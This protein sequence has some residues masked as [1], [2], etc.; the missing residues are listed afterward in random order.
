MYG[1]AGIV[2]VTKRLGRESD[3]AYRLR[4]LH[5]KSF[6]ARVGLAFG[7]I[8]TFPAIR[9]CC[10]VSYR[11]GKVTSG[12]DPHP[13]P[14]ANSKINTYFISKSSNSKANGLLEILCRHKILDN[15]VSAQS[16]MLCF[17]RSLGG[18]ESL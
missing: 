12:G 13:R 10:N 16:R 14:H 18:S 11:V 1:R 6:T 15:T 3:G 17:T 5:R 8:Q 7:E 9:H 4:T 2:T